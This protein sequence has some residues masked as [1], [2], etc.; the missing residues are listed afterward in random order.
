MDREYLH[1]RVFC[2]DELE[3]CG[4]YLTGDITEEEMQGEDAIV[5]V[6]EMAAIF[7]EQYRMGMGFKDEKYWKEKKDGRTLFW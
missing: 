1:G 5:T 2:S 6:P 3:I 4:G 7:D